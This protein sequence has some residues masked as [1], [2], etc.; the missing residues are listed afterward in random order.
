MQL[1]FATHNLNK[2]K[3][4]NALIGHKYTVL[5]LNDINWH[6]PI[7]EP[8]NTIQENAIHKARTIATATGLSCFADDSG[9]IVNALNGAPGVLSARYAG[10]EKNDT[11]NINKILLELKNIDNRTAYFITVIALII[12]EQLHLF[13]GKIDG[14]ILNQPIG[15]NGFGYDPIFMPNE[16]QLS[17]AQINLEQKNKLSHRA[18]AITAMTNYLT[19][20]NNA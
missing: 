6:Q 11:N 2:V 19:Q 14:H 12:N 3:E 10:P 1:I 18:K 13:E 20:I 17:F 15:D 8:Y 5:S 4:V 9:L 16:I 7:E